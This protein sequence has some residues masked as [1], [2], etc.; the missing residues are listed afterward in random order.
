MSQPSH[1]DLELNSDCD[2]LFLQQSWPKPFEF[3]EGVVRVF[4]DMVSR[5]VPLYRDVLISAAQWALAYYQPH[6]CII[7]IGCSTGTLLE[8]VGR[9]LSASARLIGIDNAEA[10]RSKALEKL[11]HLNSKHHIEII[12][13]AAEDCSFEH[14]SVVVMNY[15]LQFL[16]LKQ[17]RRVLQ[18]IFEGLLPGGLLFLSEK[19]ISPF[20]QFQETM[21]QNYEAFKAKN[22]YA[23]R[24]IERKKEAL[25]NVLIPLTEAQLRQMLNDCGFWAVDTLMKQHNFMTFVA[26]KSQ[27]NHAP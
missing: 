2:D 14:S 24:E 21:T 17:R 4:D 5:S 6:T 8:L 27:V 18:S 11:S 22:G 3:D 20:P 15:T 13:A 9:Q 12:C 25:E 26:L 1:D 10:M 19:V 7:D 16:P 23:R